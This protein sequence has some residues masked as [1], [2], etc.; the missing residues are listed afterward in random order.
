MKKSSDV[1]KRDLFEIFMM[2]DLSGKLI[3]IAKVVLRKITN[4]P[5]GW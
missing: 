3:I 1:S 2:Q 4:K 5:Q